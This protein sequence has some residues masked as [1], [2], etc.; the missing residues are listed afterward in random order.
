MLDS[1]ALLTTCYSMVSCSHA[2]HFDEV[3]RDNKV[4][5]TKF[6]SFS[7]VDRTKELF[8]LPLVKPVAK[9]PRQTGND[10]GSTWAAAVS[11]SQQV[12]GAW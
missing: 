9:V 6:K 8:I 5:C 11:G 12:L 1:L 3:N 4:T 7:L 2:V 10:G